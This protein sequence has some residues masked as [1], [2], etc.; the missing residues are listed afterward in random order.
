MKIL[1]GKDRRN[2]IQAFKKLK[3]SPNTE[4]L[5]H[6][7]KWLITGQGEPFGITGDSREEFKKFAEESRKELVEALKNTK[8][9]NNDDKL[10]QSICDILQIRVHDESWMDKISK[11][12]EEDFN[13]KLSLLCNENASFHNMLRWLIEAEFIDEFSFKEGEEF[14]HEMLRLAEIDRSSF[15]DG[16]PE[17]SLLISRDWHA[18]SKSDVKYPMGPASRMIGYWLRGEY[19]GSISPFEIWGEQ[20][21]EDNKKFRIDADSK[22]RRI[23]DDEGD[24]RTILNLTLYRKIRLHST[25]RVNISSFVQHSEFDSVEWTLYDQKRMNHVLSESVLGSENSEQAAMRGIEE[26]LEIKLDDID[27]AKVQKNG[28]TRLE[29]GSPSGPEGFDSRTFLGLPSLY[30]LQDYNWILDEEMQSKYLKVHNGIP[31]RKYSIHDAGEDTKLIWMP[32]FDKIEKLHIP[33]DGKMDNGV[34]YFRVLHQHEEFDWLHKLISLSITHHLENDYQNSEFISKKFNPQKQDNT[35]E[36]ENKRYV[37]TAFDKL[38]EKGSFKSKKDVGVSS[39][40]AKSKDIEAMFTSD[41]RNSTFV[42]QDSKNKEKTN[43][44]FMQKLTEIFQPVIE[45]KIA[46]QH[47]VNK[48]T[49]YRKSV[50]N[51]KETKQGMSKYAKEFSKSN[52]KRNI[53]PS[54]LDSITRDTEKLRTDLN[55]IFQIFNDPENW[56]IPLN[57]VEDD[58]KEGILTIELPKHMTES[59]LEACDCLVIQ[60]FKNGQVKVDRQN[61]N[62]AS[63]FK[64]IELKDLLNPSSGKISKQELQEANQL[65][66]QLIKMDSLI[67][68]IF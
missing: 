34:K 18:I 37:E 7:I 20:L 1:E 44:N 45:N 22:N 10:Q 17:F 66:S 48:I 23:F 56:K 32:K 43:N 39:L 30:F 41:E 14:Q 36:M 51:D 26:E 67:T 33:V 53:D 27:R 21:N 40:Y 12:S 6:N 4:K 35:K 52:L 59:Y 9:E 42:V 16:N 50:P 8:V 55:A 61:L 19:I 64:M 3:Q 68:S 60:K 11:V 58:G 49:D 24:D 38:Y 57:F 46:Y 31:T 5:D 63:V 13:S 25:S 47:L 29:L 54:E 65:I 15:K 62:V 28:E 2:A